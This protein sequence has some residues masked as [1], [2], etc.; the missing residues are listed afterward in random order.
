MKKNWTFILLSVVIFSGCDTL[1]FAPGEIQ[2]QNAWLHNR[3]AQLAADVAKDQDDF[4]TLRDLTQLSEIQS[5]AFSA[6]YGLPKEFPPAESVDDILAGNN[7]VIA[8]NATGYSAQRPD[9][10]TIT[11]GAIDLGIGLA[12]LFGGIYGVKASGFL[13]QA[14]KK[15]EA[16]REIV[17]GN[18]LFK[19]NN[20][21]SKEQFK[22]AHDSQSSK[23]R[24]IVAEIKNDQAI[25]G[26]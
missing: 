26:S 18:E 21:G 6:D 24:S 11:D 19:R 23:T 25:L 10:W 14:R 9:F 7:Y 3:T 17:I 4:E 20:A 1:R 15:S 8:R 16:L 5:R 12:A 13:R 2:K 22:A